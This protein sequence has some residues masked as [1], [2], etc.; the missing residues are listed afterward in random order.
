M[1]TKTKSLSWSGIYN[2][3]KQTG[4]NTW[5]QTQASFWTDRKKILRISSPLFLQNQKGEGRLSPWYLPSLLLNSLFL[6]L[7]SPPTT[8]WEA[9]IILPI[10]NIMQA[11]EQIQL[12][13]LYF[14]LNLINQLCIGMCNLTKI[15]RAFIAL[16][17]FLSKLVDTKALIL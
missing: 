10:T 13:L 11:M 4:A 7:R 15:R 2:R 8:I 3:T 1:L 12:R 17:H 9:L 14:L 16:A 5:N 6:R